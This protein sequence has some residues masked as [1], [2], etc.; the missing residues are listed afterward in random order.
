MTPESL[1][2]Q[3]R[4]VLADNERQFDE[5]AGRR[6]YADGKRGVLMPVPPRHGPKEAA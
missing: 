4:L 6:L 2:N 5:L 3:I 1:R